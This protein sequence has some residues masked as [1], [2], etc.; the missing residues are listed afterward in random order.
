MVAELIMEASNILRKRVNDDTSIPHSGNMS[1]ASAQSSNQAYF[2]S[3]EYYIHHE[4]FKY[5]QLLYATRHRKYTI[6]V[7]KF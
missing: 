6:I 2:R 5:G 7:S 3:Q 4:S 1:E